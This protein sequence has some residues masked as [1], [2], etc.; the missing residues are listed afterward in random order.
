MKKFF[1]IAGMIFLGLLL[2][3]TASGIYVKTMLPN[4]GAAPKITVEL[5]PPRIERGKYLANY[6]AVC[7]DCHST[8]SKD[9][10]SGPLMPGNFGGGGEKFGKDMGFPGNFYSKNITP[11]A[12]ANWTDG[13]IYRAVT[14][15]VNKDG[16]AL[17]PIMPYH[18]YGKL[19][20]EDIYSIIAYLRT[21]DPLKTNPPASEADFPVNFILNTMPAKGTP[22][23]IPAEHDLIGR[24]KYLA[25][26]ANCVD[27][28]SMKDK[29]ATV[30]GTEYGGGMEFV[31]P[32]GVVRSSNITGD[33]ATGI[34]NWTSEDFVK[35]FKMYADS[36]YVPH[37]V[38]PNEMNTAMPWM[39]Y[40]G[41]EEKDLQ[42]IYA[43]LTSLTPIDH[44]V[45]KF[46]PAK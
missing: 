18:G 30:A 37:K 36:N 22:G 20:D 14:T 23:V 35:R 44:Q 17:F 11:Y 5:T 25:T 28:H 43:Y 9:L 42:A 8:R 38:G 4:T 21:L 32:A 2:V 1:K 10:F 29:G 40:A 24:G 45:T 41:M 12:L 27:C 19:A 34:G 3:I 31:T 13:E 33:K 39:M 7:M 46:S 6:V 15:G 16:K 26:A